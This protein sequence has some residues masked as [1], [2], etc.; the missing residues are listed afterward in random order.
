MNQLITR[1]GLFDDLFRDVAPGF[2]VK[3]LHGDPLP[4]QIK[5]DVRETPQAYTL[6]AEMPGVVKEDIHVQ[7]DGNA[8]TLRAEVKQHDIQTEGEKVLRSERYCGSVARSFQLPQDIDNATS[9]AK[10]DN[11]VLVLTLPKKTAAAAGQ[12]LMV[13]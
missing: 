11:G 10:Y 9:K 6:H 8:V 7:V 1:S 4:A 2:F 5:V 12:R 13:E 3:P